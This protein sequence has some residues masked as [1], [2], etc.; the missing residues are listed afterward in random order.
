M[1]E[2]VGS[3]EV[4]KFADVVV[5]EKIF[6]TVFEETLGT[7]L[8]L[9]NMAGGEIVYEAYGGFYE[10]KGGKSGAILHGEKESPGAWRTEM[11]RRIR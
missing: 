2:V 8:V 11:C 10:W 6:L 4:G 5:L 7:N 9:L 3:L 1:D